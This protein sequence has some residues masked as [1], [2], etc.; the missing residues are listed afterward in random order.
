MTNHIEI[1]VETAKLAGE[2]LL[3]RF[4]TSFKTFEKSPSNYVTELD[5]KAEQLIVSRLLSAYPNIP[6]FAEEKN[7]Q[8]KNES[9]W[10]WIIDPLD[11]TTNYIHGY[12]FF[13][14]SIALEIENEG[15]IGV[16]YAPLLNQLYCAQRGQ[17]A[18]LN[19]SKINVSET[20]ELRLALLGSGF[21]Y[22]SWECK[23]NNSRQ[24]TDLIQ[25]VVSLRCDGSA[26]LDLCMVGSGVLDG[27]WELD[28]EPW[29]MAAG[30]LIV[31]EAGGRVTLLDG[32]DFSPYQRSVVASNNLLH[33]ELFAILNP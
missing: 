27:Y 21:P 29:D 2:L 25:R 8:S 17:G 32:S 33:N 31:Q 18:Y 30:A 24:W 23:E 14:V 5:F 9:G 4:Q 3:A 28:L 15:V 7:K 13:C 12:P 10:R 19:D 22:Y 26:A 16:V 20:K 11:G 6:I 1:A